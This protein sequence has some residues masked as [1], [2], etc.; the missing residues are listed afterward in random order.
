M[1]RLACVGTGSI[2]RRHI[3]NLVAL[4][5][6]V[7]AYDLSADALNGVPA[8]ASRHLFALDAFPITEYDAVVIATPWDQH[9]ALVELAVETR[10]PFFVEKPLGSLEQLPQWRAMAK[11]NLPINQVGY[12]L[13][14]HPEY[15]CLR[16]RNTHP[17]SGAF[18]C[19]CDMNTWPGGPYGPPLLECSH[20][21]DLMLSSGA[22][23]VVPD[24]YEDSTGLFR[25]WM[26]PW[27]FQLRY[28]CLRYRRE[29]A[30]GTSRV[31]FKSSKQ[32]GT[33]MYVDEMAHFLQCIREHTATSVPLADGL[34]VLEVCA[35][36][37]AL[38]PSSR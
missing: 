33:K 20:E 10:T 18:M 12:M 22:P 5:C 32:L 3:A 30:L 27:A 7:A 13:R 6:A 24:T 26:G 1:L 8:G 11:R 35:H 9:L 23:N 34:R 21:L 31:K 38:C 28:E 2:G 36:V 14:F 29:W 16:E 4:G 19:E 37:E 15:I 17:R 25:L